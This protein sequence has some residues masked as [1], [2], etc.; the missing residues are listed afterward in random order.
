M[1]ILLNEDG[2]TWV[3]TVENITDEELVGKFCF[4]WNGEE[5]EKAEIDV[6]TDFNEGDECPFISR[7]TT[8]MCAMEF[9]VNNARAI[10]S[11][12]SDR[13]GAKTPSDIIEELIADQKALYENMSFDDLVEH[14]QV[15]DPEFKLENLNWRT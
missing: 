10:L 15:I 5:L 9:N 12:I 8:F 1:I 6:V 14:Y 13:G 4:L 7:D 11:T 2:S 3:P